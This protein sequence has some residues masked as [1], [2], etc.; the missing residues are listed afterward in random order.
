MSTIRGAKLGMG[1]RS[2]NQRPA[3]KTCLHADESPVAQGNC[4][5]WFCKKGGFTTTAM[6]ICNQH[7]LRPIPGATESNT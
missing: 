7:S 4:S 2:S 1:Y 5:R 6:A 3:C